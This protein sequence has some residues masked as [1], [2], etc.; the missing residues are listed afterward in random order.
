ML[1]NR[2]LQH[3]L[4]RLLLVVGTIFVLLMVSFV[5]EYCPAW[6]SFVDHRGSSYMRHAL[7]F[8][9]KKYVPLILVCQSQGIDWNWDPVTRLV[10]IAKSNRRIVLAPGCKK[11][12]VESSTVELNRPV[13]IYKGSILV[14]AT[15]VRRLLAY[16]RPAVS[17]P[18]MPRHPRIYSMK[19]VVID[20]GHGGR[21]PGA[22]GCFGLKE[23]DIV[24]DI[25][26]RL[27]RLLQQQGLEVIMTRAD[28]RFVPLGKRAR[29]ANESEAD[30]F[31]SIHANSARH[32]RADGFEVYYLSEA[33]DDN[34]RAVAAAENAVLKFEKDSAVSLNNASAAIVWDIINTENRRESIEL[35]ETLCAAVKGRSL[36]KSRG[37]KGANFYV[38]RGTRMPAVLVEVGFISNRQ[39]ASRLADSRYRQKI[40][41]TLAAGIIEY[42]QLYEKSNGFTSPL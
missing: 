13:V 28:D 39:E 23:K 11:I 19:R 15:E 35:A 14:P 27:R 4:K 6:A 24:L 16:F 21:D 37:V 38:L 22:I 1:Y 32:Q 10:S 8:K 41:E 9:G 36:L 26:L 5:S 30:F 34:A 29:I 42:K 40:A 18:D 2:D 3:S 7:W 17:K 20:P 25:A 33:I 31:I 12:L